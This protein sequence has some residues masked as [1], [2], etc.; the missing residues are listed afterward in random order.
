M[1]TQVSKEQFASA[2]EDLGHNP[3]EYEG[4]KLSLAGMSELYE[5]R[6][7]DILDA[8]EGKFISAHYDYMNDTIWIDALDAAH[9][10]F[11][12]RANMSLFDKQVA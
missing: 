4:K 12:M 1:P 10:F 3:S 2:L 8:I 6:Q 7:N 11:C 9:F 5:M